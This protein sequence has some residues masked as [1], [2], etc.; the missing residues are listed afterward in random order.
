MSQILPFRHV[1]VVIRHWSNSSPPTPLT[2]WR[3]YSRHRFLNNKVLILHDGWERSVCFSHPIANPR[4]FCAV[5]F[6]FSPWNTSQNHFSFKDTMAVKIVIILLFGLPQKP[7]DSYLY[8]YQSAAHDHR[9]HLPSI[10]RNDSASLLKHLQ[11]TSII[12]YVYSKFLIMMRELPMNA[13]V[14]RLPR[15][16]F[17]SELILQVKQICLLPPMLSPVSESGH[18]FSFLCSPS[19]VFLIPFP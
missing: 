14:L 4:K 16:L 3:V 2:P 13:S 17:P 9:M 7:S 19:V 10:F 15:H 11:G 5:C 8:L 18:T 6:F 1:S 12:P